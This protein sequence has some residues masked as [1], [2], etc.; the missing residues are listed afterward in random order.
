MAGPMPGVF[1]GRRMGCDFAVVRKVLVLPPSSMIG[2]F[3]GS[4]DWRGVG[5]AGVMLGVLF[6]WRMG[7]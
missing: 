2:V 7:G 1:F 6:G 5:F 3:H 4:A